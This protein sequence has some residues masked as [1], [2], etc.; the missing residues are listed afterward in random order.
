LTAEPRS[1][2]GAVRP[3]RRARPSNLVSFHSGERGTDD[4]AWVAV[5]PQDRGGELSAPVRDPATA[6]CVWLCPLRR[7]PACMPRGAW[8]LCRAHP[9]RSSLLRVPDADFGRT[10][11]SFVPLPDGRTTRQRC[12]GS[13]LWS[14]T[15]LADLLVG[16]WLLL[17]RCFGG[18]ASVRERGPGAAA[19]SRARVSGAQRARRSGSSGL[20]KRSRCFEGWP[21]RFGSAVPNNLGRRYFRGVVSG[22]D[23]C[24]TVTALKELLRGSSQRR[25][26][27]GS[28]R[29]GRRVGGGVPVFRF[30]AAFRLRPPP[31]CTRGEHAPTPSGGRPRLSLDADLLAE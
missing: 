9:A 17:G 28:S 25:E 1:V 4:G 24:S 16:S 23:L 31:K 30:V 18:P 15:R 8:A 2:I 10:T 26:A 29:G 6:G 13:V 7:G 12:G 5:G 19:L 21:K 22:R 20:N 11:G 14:P 27:G 3:R